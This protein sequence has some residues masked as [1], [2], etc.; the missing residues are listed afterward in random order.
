M[1]VERKGPERITKQE[2]TFS[3]EISPANFTEALSTLKIPT[4]RATID[5]SS[6]THEY[7]LTNN[8]AAS[9]EWHRESGFTFTDL[10]RFPDGFEEKRS[11]PLPFIAPV[12]ADHRMD[13]SFI[14][15]KTYPMIEVDIYEKRR[16]TGKGFEEFQHEVLPRLI[17]AGYVAKEGTIF[18][19]D[20]G[21]V[22]SFDSA[23]LTFNQDELRLDINNFNKPQFRDQVTNWWQTLPTTPAKK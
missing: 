3:R 9:I 2:T 20:K 21:L 17:D 6:Q 23:V 19:C 22:G 8:V 16:E 18:L 13:K 7:A 10:R 11:Y 4:L 1:G 14:D 15:E 12:G 5:F